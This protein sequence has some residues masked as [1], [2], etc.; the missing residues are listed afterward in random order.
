MKPVKLEDFNFKHKK[1]IKINGSRPSTAKS[2][3]TFAN[4]F[5]MLTCNNCGTGKGK[6]GGCFSSD[7]E[8][9]DVSDA[10]ASAI[11]N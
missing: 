4:S 1:N 2:T 7:V 10:G 3:S 9:L 6:G 11:D 5:Y 8:N